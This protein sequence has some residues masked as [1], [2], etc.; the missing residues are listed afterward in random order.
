MKIYLIDSNKY[1]EC[2]LV[3][4]WIQLHFDCTYL[5]SITNELIS[6]K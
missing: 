3:G 1:N 4:E 2:Y 6:N 5:N